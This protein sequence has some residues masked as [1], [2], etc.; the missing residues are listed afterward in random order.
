[1]SRRVALISE[2]ASPFAV[3]GGVDAGGQNIYVSQLARHLAALGWQVD[4]FTRRDNDRLPEVAD[5]VDGV[6]LIH[7]PAGPPRFV[8]KEELLPFM[9]DFADYMIAFARRQYPTYELAHA[10]FWMS[11]YVAMRLKRRLELPFAVT[12]HAL[13]KVRRLH[14]KEADQFPRAR[15]RIEEKICEAADRIVA[16]CPQDEKDLLE[17]YGADPDKLRMIGCGFDPREFSPV[18][19]ILARAAL[20]LDPSERIVLQLGRIVP[21]KGIDNVIRGIARLRDRYGIQAKLLIVGGDAPQPD[22]VKTPEIGRLSQ[23][24]SDH[25]LDGQV[26][27]TG[28]RGREM[29]KYFYSAA[30]VFVTTPWY[31]P[32]GITPL[33]SM[34]CGTP[35]ICSNVGGLK[36][37]VRDGQTGFHVPPNDPDALADR[38]SVLF[39]SPALAMAMQKH[40]IAH[41]R[42]HFMWK[43]VATELDRVYSELGGTE[44]GRVTFPIREPMRAT[45]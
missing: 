30:D 27:F 7:V 40:A 22:P 24:V 9:D 4:V 28:G 29:L 33:E 1:M 17:L 37:S 8:R 36:H 20:G 31:E 26:V 3:I 41:V 38:L 42:E 21:R 18:G 14:Q 5:W 34:A 11:G 10:N 16:E 35:V 25:R 13:G 19:K 15:L 45:A 43:K 6:R 2:H 32:F 44:E 39:H 23:I 12:F